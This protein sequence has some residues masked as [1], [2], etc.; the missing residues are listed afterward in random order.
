GTEFNHEAEASV[1]VKVSATPTPSGITTLGED[2]AQ[3]SH[4]EYMVVIQDENETPTDLTLTATSLI[5]GQTTVGTVAV[6]DAD[7]PAVSQYSFA[8][9]A[10]TAALD[11][12]SFMI[13]PGGVLAL[14]DGA[15]R[16]ALGES[17]QVEIVVTDRHDNGGVASLT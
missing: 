17:Y 12:E 15:N 13:T 9:T 1:T 16:K 5:P 2:E 3:L 11:N 10:D 7:D 6:V 4:R 14:K 8:L